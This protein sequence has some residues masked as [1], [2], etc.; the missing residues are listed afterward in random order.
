MQ[1]LNRWNGSVIAEG[2]MSLRELILVKIKSGANLYG[3]DLHG[4]NLHG[5]NLHGADLHGADLHGANLHGANL[6]GADLY[7]AD[8]HGANLHGADLYGANLD[9]SA[10]PLQ[11]SSLKAKVDDHISAQL[12]YHAFAVSAVIPTAEQ[13]EF[14]QKNFHRFDECGG[15]NTITIKPAK[16]SP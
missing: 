1:I 2:E 14:M 10:W 11:C 3:A 5:A 15:V 6:Y 9:Y 4:A 13:V 8:L 12:L 16:E 7:G